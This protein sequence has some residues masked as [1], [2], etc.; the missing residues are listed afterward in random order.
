MEDQLVQLLANTQLSEQGPRQQAEI[1]LKHARTNPAFP[2]SLANIAGHT[3]ID[4]AIRQ[5]ALSTLRLFIE[6][7]WNAEDRDL[8]EPEITISD[9]AREQLRH[10]LLEVALSN[11]D[12]RRVKIAA[13]YE[14]I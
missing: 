1:E 12:N 13:R 6:K 10:A 4:T 11:E 9:A 8:A 5:S 2:T 3:S 14:H 7:N